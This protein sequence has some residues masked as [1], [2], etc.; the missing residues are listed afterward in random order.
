MGCDE[1]CP[2]SLTEVE[3]RSASNLGNFY[4]IPSAAPAGPK[5]TQSPR[6]ANS[7]Y[8]WMETQS[9]EPMVGDLDKY[10]EWDTD[11]VQDRSRTPSPTAVIDKPMQGEAVE[12][13]PREAK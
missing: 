1:G 9:P 3:S 5:A 2:S 7:E 4:P 6:G 12:E 11:D 13:T 10:I 8:K